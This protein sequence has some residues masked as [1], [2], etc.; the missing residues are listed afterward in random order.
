MGPI[1]KDQALGRI[2][3]PET[4]VTN[5]QYALRNIT[6]QNISHWQHVEGLKSRKGTLNS[7]SAYTNLLLIG[8]FSVFSVT[9]ICRYSS[10]NSF[11]KTPLSPL[12]KG[13]TFHERCSVLRASDDN[14]LTATALSHELVK[15]YTSESTRFIMSLYKQHEE[16]TA[17]YVH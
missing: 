1:F 3:C 12:R 5:N 6:K 16:K 10:T 14:L 9:L 2:G 13:R 4:S 8:I 15:F 11:I 17:S 7:K